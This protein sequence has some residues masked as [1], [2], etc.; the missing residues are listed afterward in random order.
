MFRPGEA[1]R[2]MAGGTVELYAAIANGGPAAVAAVDGRVA[3]VI[4]LELTD[5]G[6]AA[7]RSQA[8]PD[9]LA[10][11]TARWAAGG[12]GAPLLRAF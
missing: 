2:A 10:R 9:K 11:A 12:H 5:G 6:I 8:N 7:V 4:C 1:K 3:D